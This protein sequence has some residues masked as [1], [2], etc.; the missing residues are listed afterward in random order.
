[1]RLDRE[2]N[3]QGGRAGMGFAKERREREGERERGN[4][5]GK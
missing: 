5:G 3:E 2:G 4:N 1:M